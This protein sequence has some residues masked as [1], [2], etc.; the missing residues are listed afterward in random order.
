M[1]PKHAE[2]EGATSVAPPA[3]FFE[4]VHIE[5]S[6]R[7]MVQVYFETELIPMFVPLCAPD[8]HF[9]VGPQPPHILHPFLKGVVRQ[10]I[11]NN[12]K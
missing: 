6:I 12:K 2:H 10:I 11:K 1:K 8:V 4:L 7:S 5:D 9:F 3:Q